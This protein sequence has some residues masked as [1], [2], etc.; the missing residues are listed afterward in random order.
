V[1]SDRSWQA[2]CEFN[3]AGGCLNL[4]PLVRGSCMAEVDVAG[5]AFGMLFVGLGILDCCGEAC[6]VGVRAPYFGCIWLGMPGLTAAGVWSCMAAGFRGGRIQL[7]S[8]MAPCGK[9]SWLAAGAS[10]GAFSSTDDWTTFVDACSFL[11][12][13]ARNCAAGYIRSAPPV[14]CVTTHGPAQPIVAAEPADE[15]R[16]DPSRLGLLATETTR[17]IVLLMLSIKCDG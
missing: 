8:W 9:M 12:C 17:N 5:A 10:R 1:V 14:R 4:P 3:P 7:T 13:L 15:T 6:L 2:C 11:E 16:L